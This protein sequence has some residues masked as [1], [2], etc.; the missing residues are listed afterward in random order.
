MKPDEEGSPYLHRLVCAGHCG[1][2]MKAADA[3][4]THRPDVTH[5]GK[6]IRMHCPSAGAKVSGSLGSKQGCHRARRDREPDPRNV[7]LNLSKLSFGCHNRPQ[8]RVTNNSGW[9]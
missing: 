4:Q 3:Q 5:K 1:V 8:R 2:T 6:V 7:V 9:P